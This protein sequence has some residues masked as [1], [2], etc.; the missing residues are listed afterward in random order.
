[1][2]INFEISDIS[3]YR[4]ELMGWAILWIMMLHFSISHIKTIGAIGQYGFA[5]VDVFMMVSGFGLFYSLERSNSV[6]DFY[7]KRIFRIFPTYYFLG[8]FASVLIYHDNILSF[9]FRFSTIG[10]WTGGIYAD[11]YIP[12]ILFLYF[13]SPLIKKMYDKRLFG[14][15]FTISLIIILVTFLIVSKQYIEKSDPHF[16]LLY[17]IPAFI[18]GMTCAYWIKSNANT[19]CY[20]NTMIICIPFFLLLYPH[21][22]YIYNFKYFSLLFLLPFIIFIQIYITK[23]ISKFSI[24]F[25]I[26]GKSSLEIYIIQGMF[27]YVILNGKLSFSQE[28][29]DIISFILI[30]ASLTIGIT[31]HFLISKLM[32]KIINPKNK[33]E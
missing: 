25:S 4:S 7:K 12:S 20:L 13:A 14:T 30:M 6:I 8:I 5:G 10:F 33:N 24:I 3:T 23:I 16:F 31:A 22:H 19:I 11:W 2:R 15:I 28:W 21:H 18:F 26:I 32:A 1:M 29:H 17:R 9:L 27:Y